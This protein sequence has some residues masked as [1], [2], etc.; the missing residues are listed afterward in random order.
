MG[1]HFG[2]CVEPRPAPSPGSPGSPTPDQCHHERCYA[3][4]CSYGV[5]EEADADTDADADADAAGPWGAAAWEPW[6]SFVWWGSPSMSLNTVW[7]RP[8]RR[9][10]S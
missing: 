7:E 6:Q 1:A 10:W 5:E 9:G 8:G 4:C 2:E 3:H